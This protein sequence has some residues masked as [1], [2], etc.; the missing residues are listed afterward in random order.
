MDG[1]LE[2][3]IPSRVDVL[4]A[5]SDDKAL[6]LI[7]AIAST[8]DNDTYTLRGKTKLSHKQYY[9]RMCDLIK[10]GLVGKKDGI[11][12]VT[13]FGKVFC[14]L[15]MTAEDLLSNY[16]KLKA[17]DTFDN[18][19]KEEYHQLVNNMIDN[20]YIKEILTKEYYPSCPALNN[21]SI[22]R[23]LV[24]NYNQHMQE[25]SS[26]IRILLI[27]DEPDTLLTYKKFLS[28][29]LG[30]NVD[31]FA[32]SYEALKHFI[33]LN[34]SYYD[35]LVTDIRMPGFNGLQLYQKMKAIDNTVRVLF[36][37]A[38]D[39]LQEMVSIFPELDFS[40]IIRKPINQQAFLDKVRMA[41]A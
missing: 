23:S 9:S 15:Q 37:S 29:A 24:T 6:A 34:H 3:S 30:I 41:L 38:V 13:S 4:N 32:D 22:Q 11:Y 36:V 2:K 1:K 28:A 8:N 17:I 20:S 10:A 25:K 35:L 16:W 7:K 26:S 21:V 18:L 12:F 40:N 14:D 39:T 31:A 33:N 27:D 19:S 5:L